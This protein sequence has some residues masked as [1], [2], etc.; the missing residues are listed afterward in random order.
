MK[1]LLTL[2]LVFALV[3]CGGEQVVQETPTNHFAHFDNYCI[4]IIDYKISMEGT[5]ILYLENGTKMITNKEV[6]ITEGE[7]CPLHITISK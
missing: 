1:K 7:R 6:I 5:F 3:G 4:K 2:L